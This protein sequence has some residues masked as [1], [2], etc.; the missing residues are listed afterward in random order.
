MTTHRHARKLPDTHTFSQQLNLPRRHDSSLRE[1]GYSVLPF[2]SCKC[3][4]RCWGEGLGRQC[5][6]F[7]LNGERFCKTHLNKYNNLKEK[8]LD[9]A[10]GHYD[11]ERPTHHLDKPHPVPLAWKN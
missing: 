8:G 5:S 2:N 1:I 10:F 9:L 4:A 6:R 7:H 3:A 11:G